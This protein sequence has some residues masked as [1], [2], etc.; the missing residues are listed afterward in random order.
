M[1]NV[2]SSAAFPAE[3]CEIRLRKAK[4]RAA[5]SRE[6]RGNQHVVFAP[7]GLV[8]SFLL[9]VLLG[10]RESPTPDIMCTGLEG[11]QRDGGSS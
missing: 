9:A 8:I 3:S 5:F 10:R 6:E 1:V 7:L 11:K 4:H 2:L